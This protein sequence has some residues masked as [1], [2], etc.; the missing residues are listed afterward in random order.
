MRAD[1][2]HHVIAAAHRRAEQTRQRAIAT[3][4]RMNSTGQRI[5]DALARA[6]GQ[7]RA[8]EVLGQAISHDT[9]NG[10]SSNLIG[11]C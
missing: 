7:Q 6:L 1:N 8:A 10:N 11:S 4:R 2:T 9:A 5:T 3:L